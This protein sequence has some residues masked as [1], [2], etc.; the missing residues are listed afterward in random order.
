MGGRTKN[1]KNHLLVFVSLLRQRT[2]N[3]L[4]SLLL[5]GPS[6][7]KVIIHLLVEFLHGF[8]GS[9]TRTT[10][11]ATKTPE[12]R[13]V[14][15]AITPAVVVAIAVV[16][17]VFPATA[18]TRA[19]MSYSTT[20]IAAADCRLATTGALATALGGDVAVNVRWCGTAGRVATRVSLWGV[21]IATSVV[22]GG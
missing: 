5:L 8:P 16:G 3:L 11:A 20:R 1:L 21:G 7:H 4:L 18:T 9:I 2:A 15:I 12:P 13:S 22:A 14:S 10:A 6:V 17:P 19:R